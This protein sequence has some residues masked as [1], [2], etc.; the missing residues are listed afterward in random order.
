M[1]ERAGGDAKHLPGQIM[2]ALSDRKQLRPLGVDPAK[3]GARGND[4]E[5]FNARMADMQKDQ[6][7]YQRLLHQMVQGSKPSDWPHALGR[8]ILAHLESRTLE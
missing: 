5:Y 2:R 6:E 1:W 4:I 8:Q 3:H 7:N